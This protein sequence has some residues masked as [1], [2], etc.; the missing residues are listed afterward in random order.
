MLARA[1]AFAGF[2]S[3]LTAGAVTACLL[4]ASADVSAKGKAAKGGVEVTFTGYQSLGG[5]RGLVFVEL[6]ELTAVEVHKSGQMVEYKLIGAR[7]P[8]RNNRN[9]LL[10]RDFSSSAITAVLVPDKKAVRLVITLRS[11]VTPTHRMVARG[12][13]AVLEVELPAPP[14]K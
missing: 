5:G 11:A 6:S 10:L 2:S 1:R 3:L 7:V 8:L 4:C 14:A 12:K 13:G 9:P